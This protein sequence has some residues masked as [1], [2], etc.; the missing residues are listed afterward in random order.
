MKTKENL[1]RQAD[2]RKIME[3][4]KTNTRKHDP[5]DQ[6]C[7]CEKCVQRHLSD[8]LW[9]LTSPPGTNVSLYHQN[10]PLDAGLKADMEE[11]F[12]RAFCPGLYK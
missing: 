11:T 12:R 8:V 6:C 3:S 10:Q 9:I 5:E 2:G 4:S 1:G 7:V